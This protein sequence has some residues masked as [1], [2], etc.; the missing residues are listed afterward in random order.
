M[1]GKFT[2]RAENGQTR[3]KRKAL[4][5]SRYGLVFHCLNDFHRYFFAL[6]LF[7]GCFTHGER[8][9]TEEKRTSEKKEKETEK[10]NDIYMRKRTTTKK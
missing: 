10:K 8:I 1:V 3:A 7:F 5:S 2:V 4:K 6:L 9:S